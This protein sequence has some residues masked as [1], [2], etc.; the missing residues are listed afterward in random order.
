MTSVPA[1]SGL[2]IVDKPEGFTSMGVCSR[3]RGRL[4]RAGD[5]KRIKVGHAGTLDPLATGVLVVLVGNA[6]RLSGRLMS[7]DKRYLADI[8]LSAFT[9]TDDREGERT[10][11]SVPAPPSPETIVAACRRFTGTIMQA[12]PAYSAIKVD[13]KRAYRLA[14]AG[15]SPALDPRPV[16]IHAIDVIDYVWPRL[17]LDVRCAKGVY[18]RSLARDI[19]RALNTGG[20]LASLR[21]TQVGRYTIDVA[22]PL[23]ALPDPITQANLIDAREI[24]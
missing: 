18:I 11:V 10:P 20:T 19:G 24:G 1:P 17:S 21:R 5:P 13:G 4:K 8:D 9:T 22:T 15:Q 14:R 6:T 12:P 23:D 2:L 7:T 16:T 3:I